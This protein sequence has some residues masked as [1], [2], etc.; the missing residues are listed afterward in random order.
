MLGEWL[1]KQSDASIAARWQLPGEFV[2]WS[3]APIEAARWTFAGRAEVIFN[4]TQFEVFGPSF[5]GAKINY[6]G[7][8]ALSW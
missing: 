1:R 4:D 6:N 8:R 7:D 5:E 3:L 2:P